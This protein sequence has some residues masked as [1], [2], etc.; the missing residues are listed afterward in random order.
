MDSWVDYKKKLTEQYKEKQNP[1]MQAIINEVE[2]AIR[3]T[4]KIMQIAVDSAR[5]RVENAEKV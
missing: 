3:K 5:A 4:K 1:N 2:T